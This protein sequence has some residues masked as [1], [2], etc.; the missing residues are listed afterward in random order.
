[1]RDRQTVTW[2]QVSQ[3][4][5]GIEGGTLRK[6]GGLRER[7][8][9][10]DDY[11]SYCREERNFAAVLYHLLLDEKRLGAFLELIG[12][13]AAQGEG[14]RIYFEYAHLRDLWA[15]VG[16]RH[17]TAD[18]RNARYRE[19]VIVML[20]HPDIALPMDCKAFNEFF[21]GPGSKA[22]SANHIQ[23]P[24]RWNDA[25]FDAWYAHGGET[26]AQRA[27][28][29]KWAFNAKPDL[30]LH[31]GGNRA[32]CIEA[33]LESGIG[34]Y[35]ARTD[36]RPDP[37][38]MTQTRLQEFIFNDLLGYATDFVIVSKDRKRYPTPP[39]RRHTW[40]RVFEALLGEPCSSRMVAEFR[41]S[42]FILPA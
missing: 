7:L 1:M 34:G 17:A 11:V 31:L 32:V 25:R 4:I 24:S 15:E 22:A 41:R 9:I 26:F 13:T 18:E 28:M 3:N 37:F 10:T 35:K 19:A 8:G 39:W 42:K 38:G 36:Q 40:H 30:V 2:G 33:K 6:D 14:A 21:I 29:L 23:M 27:C 5:H 20:R 12:L 16:T